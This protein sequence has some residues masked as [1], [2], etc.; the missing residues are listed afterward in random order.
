MTTANPIEFCPAAAC[1]AAVVRLENLIAHVDRLKEQAALARSAD[2]IERLEEI[3]DELM[4]TAEDARS[5]LAQVEA[6]SAAGAMAQLL[7]AIRDVRVRDDA[8][9]HRARKLEARAVRFLGTAGLFDAHFCRQVSQ[10][11]TARAPYPASRAI[12]ASESS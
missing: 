1:A 5:R 2:L 10:T 3:A 8:E 11:V 12:S 9:R 7:A 6:V 4:M